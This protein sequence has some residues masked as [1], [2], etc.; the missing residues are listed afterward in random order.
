M[1]CLEGAYLDGLD[2][3]REHP[4]HAEVHGLDG[5]QV[6]VCLDLDVGISAHD[7]VLQ[8]LSGL[9]DCDGDAVL[10][11]RMCWGGSMTVAA[12]GQR[13]CQLL[14]SYGCLVV[15]VMPMW[16]QQ[17]VNVMCRCTH[18]RSHLHKAGTLHG[19]SRTQIA[20]HNVMCWSTCPC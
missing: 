14:H 9:H 4:E 16:L 18:I 10:Q 3:V 12:L 8:L 5:G 6:K 7:G 13:L 1:V 2:G 17:P 20:M 11:D 19:R 15:H